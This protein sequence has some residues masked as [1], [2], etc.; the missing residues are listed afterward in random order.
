M[1]ANASAG[2]QLRGTAMYRERM[3]LPTDAIF[4]ATL[5]DVSRADAPATVIGR[6]RLEPA[7]HPPFRFAIH[8]DP[9]RLEP[10]HSYSVRAR[11]MAAGQLLFTTDR[12]YALPSAGEELSIQLVRTQSAPAPA[13]IAALENT[14]WKLL[15][16][17]T[18]TVNLGAQQREP[19]LVLHSQGKRVAGTGG[20]NR[21]IGAYAVSGEELKF[22]QMGGT[23]MAC[24][25]GM[26]YE[27][28]FHD[29]LMNVSRWR[30]DGERLELFDS[31][32]TSLALLESRYM[33]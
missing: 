26:Q 12:Q 29:A 2:A 7:G 18:E 6:A 20:C 24:P 23:M 30:I 14:Y 11:V 27:R 1:E 22:S 3:S 32:G 19:H 13:G 10:G 8:Y 31:A 15:R 28:A 9:L 4:E 5:E 16:V 33:R 21:I 25:D 17:G